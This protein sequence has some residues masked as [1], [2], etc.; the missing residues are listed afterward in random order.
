MVAGGSTSTDMAQLWHSCGTAVAQLWLYEHRYGTAM[1]QLWHSY[2]STST[3][4]AR[5]WPEHAKQAALVVQLSAEQ[6]E[7]HN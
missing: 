6:R 3:D 5:L 1:A 7:A 2:G 4:M